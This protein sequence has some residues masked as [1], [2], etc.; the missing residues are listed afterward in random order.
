MFGKHIQTHIV[1][2][3][4]PHTASQVCVLESI[5]FSHIWEEAISVGLILF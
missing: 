3:N 5:A 2:N 1:K 4:I